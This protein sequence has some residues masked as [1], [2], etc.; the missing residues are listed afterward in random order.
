METY[1]SEPKPPKGKP[2]PSPKRQ[3]LGPDERWARTDELSGFGD[4]ELARQVN[5]QVE[6]AMARRRAQGR[7]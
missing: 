5:E 6:E 1:K 3:S 2:Q 7:I 4:T